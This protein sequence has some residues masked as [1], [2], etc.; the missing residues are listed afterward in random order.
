MTISINV[1]LNG[2]RNVLTFKS[3]DTVARQKYHRRFFP[4]V[5]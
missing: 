2:A 5:S 4:Q 1:F 3:E